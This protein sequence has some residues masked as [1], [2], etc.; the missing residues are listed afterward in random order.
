[1]CQMS[2]VMEKDGAEEVVMENVTQ[3]Q[4]SGTTIEVNA[5]FEEPL[6][7][8]EVSIQS[9]DF[10]AGKLVVKKNSGSE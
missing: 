5:F 8:E 6:R 2:V 7:L 1:M 9:I 3:L 4:V 10:L